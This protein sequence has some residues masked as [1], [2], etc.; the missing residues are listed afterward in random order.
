MKNHPE[1]MGTSG[2]V[3]VRGVT[4]R[5]I[6]EHSRCAIVAKKRQGGTKIRCTF[7]HVGMFADRL[8]LIHAVQ[9]YHGLHTS[10]AQDV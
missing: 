9:K 10:R 3:G 6:P 8:L 4:R 7:P 2:Q 1:S 5:I